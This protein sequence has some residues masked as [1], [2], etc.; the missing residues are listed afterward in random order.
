MLALSLPLDAHSRG[1][2]GSGG[3]SGGGGSS[4]GSGRSS[5]GGGG[6]YHGRSRNREAYDSGLYRREGFLEHLFWGPSTRFGYYSTGPYRSPSR[7][8]DGLALIILLGAAVRF[9]F[10]K[11]RPVNGSRNTLGFSAVSPSAAVQKADAT[12][13]LFR[14]QS[15]RDPRFEWEGTLRTIRHAFLTL[16]QSWSARDYRMMAPLVFPHLRKSHE[17]QIAT[18]VR[19]RE[20]NK[21]EEVE[22]L[23]IRIIQ[24]TIQAARNTYAFSAFITAK[25]RDYTL[26]EPDGKMIRGSMEVETFEEFWTFQHD[27]KAWL[28]REIDQVDTSTLLYEPNSVDWTHGLREQE[29]PLMPDLDPRGK[30]SRWI[31]NQSKRNPIWQEDRMRSFGRTLALAY[32]E[33]LET[34]SLEK[35]HPVV[36]SEYS[37]SLK[38]ILK[39]SEGRDL[40]HRNLCTK[41]AEITWVS[42]SP[43][44]FNVTVKMHAQ[45]VVL[46]G[47]RVIQSDPDILPF[48]MI[49]QFIEEPPRGRFL[50]N[51]V[52]TI[53]RS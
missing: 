50:L 1:G 31:R 46:E 43:P 52:K 3:R 48:E 51:S 10:G 15:N 49:L 25:A 26:R 6:G 23:D 20:V 44:A 34:K 24:L 14:E 5:F 16:Q 36:T 45:R 13:K 42:E 35:I 17:S 28:L 4:G 37:R 9:L 12:E 47:Q 27:G 7:R 53:Q 21:M 19:H 8:F 40:E 33:A 39:Q 32:I 30:I 22:I 38:E 18:L 41:S 11:M 29:D 2:G